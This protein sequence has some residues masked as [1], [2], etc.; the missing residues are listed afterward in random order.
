MDDSIKLLL[1]CLS[2]I[3]VF[4]WLFWLQIRNMRFERSNET[5]RERVNIS[6][7]IDKLVETVKV[8]EKEISLDE[9]KEKL[10][11]AFLK[12]INQI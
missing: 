4:G 3:L 12:L 6:I 7:H 2:I 8:E 9:A 11:D 1:I 5:S 10:H